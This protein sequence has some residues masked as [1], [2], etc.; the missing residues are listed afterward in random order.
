MEAF[1]F[2]L[3]RL[4]KYRENL[5]KKS[6]AALAAVVG[7]CNRLQQALT[8]SK[9]EEREAFVR[10]RQESDLDAWRLAEIFSQKAKSDQKKLAAEIESKEAQKSKLAADYAEKLKQQRILEKLKERQ[11]KEYKL[12]RARWAEKQMDDTLAALACQA[13]RQYAGVEKE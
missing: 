12:T 2:R 10:F 11:R 6:E 1:K 3:E 7:E 4:L 8:Q 13:D 5:T 9:L